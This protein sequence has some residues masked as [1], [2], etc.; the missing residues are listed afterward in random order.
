MAVVVVAA[1]VLVG[2]KEAA[3]VAAEALQEQVEVAWEEVGKEAGNASLESEDE[4]SQ[5][6]LRAE[7]LGALAAYLGALGTASAYPLLF[8]VSIE[9]LDTLSGT[10]I[11]DRLRGDNEKVESDL[12]GLAMCARLC[13]LSDDGSGESDATQSAAAALDVFRLGNLGPHNDLD[14]AILVASAAASQL[15]MLNEKPVAEAKAVQPVAVRPE[16]MAMASALRRS[17]A[18]VLCRLCESDDV[19]SMF[20]I[21]GWALAWKANLNSA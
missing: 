19:G 12:E 8:G 21:A 9:D 11:D 13:A 7:P 17:E 6:R 10:E 18:M 4:W 5:A 3:V 15:S 1:V 16:C 14:A 2:A 20:G